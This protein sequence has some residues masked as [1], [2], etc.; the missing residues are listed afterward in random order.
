MNEQ[1]II[2][3]I[4]EEAIELEIIE[5]KP[6]KIGING[7]VSVIDLAINTDLNLIYNISKL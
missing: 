1:I 7:G 6:L 2:D 5:E 3:I 4:L